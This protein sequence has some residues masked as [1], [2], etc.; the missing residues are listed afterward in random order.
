MKRSALLKLSLMGLFIISLCIPALAVTIT[1]NPD[2]IN[3]GGQIIISIQDLPDNSEFS[4]L[5]EGTFGT[6]PG[7]RFS[8]GT[9]N[10]NIP[11]TLSNG[12]T[13]ATTENTATTG[14]TV[15]KSGSGSTFRV[16]GSSSNG[17]YTTTS[18]GDISAG[19]YE[20]LL[21][22]G[23]ALPN[24]N[25]IMTQLNMRGTKTG[26]VNSQISFNIDGIDSGEVRITVL[27]NGQQTLYKKVTIGTPVVSA[28]GATSAPVAPQMTNQITPG[29]TGTTEITP[30]PISDITLYYS[31]DRLVS[32]GAQ[33]VDYIGL[34]S[35]DAKNIPEG[36]IK[37]GDAYTI[38]PNDLVLSPA[39]DL[40]FTLPAQGNSAADYAYFIAQY[41][42][43]IW[44][45]VPT[46]PVDNAIK[47]KVNAA[48]TYALM[49]LK[50]ESNIPSAGA[51]PG[52]VTKSA[53]PKIASVAKAAPETT[54]KP[55]PLSI[56]PV[57]GACL[58]CIL[59]YKRSKQ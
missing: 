40:T 21:F 39:A 4:L 58:I 45:I 43:G 26:P 3:R 42:N 24:K 46:S 27:V 7:A 30:A 53:T 34:L 35:V 12:R 48:G 17:I 25:Q 36:W 20:T 14:F 37:F 18:E 59:V 10:L 56:I 57:I 19:V 31:A 52:E 6:Q 9:N 1:E 28:P 5:I 13:S 50:S 23:I 15:K 16:A 32:I 11:F 2:T 8:F 41:Q 55:A 29:V 33:G 49:A 51:T 38:V 22:E 44:N 47:S 54:S